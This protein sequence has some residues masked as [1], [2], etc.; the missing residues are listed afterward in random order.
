MIAEFALLS[1]ILRDFTCK[2]SDIRFQSEKY[3]ELNVIAFCDWPKIG[4]L[5]LF[6][7]LGENNKIFF[8]KGSFKKTKEISYY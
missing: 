8:W 2:I 3:K 7:E 5:I 4:C 1:S 6:S